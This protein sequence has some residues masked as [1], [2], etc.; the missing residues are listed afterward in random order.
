MLQSDGKQTGSG[1]GIK[2]IRAIIFDLNETLI[3]RNET[4]RLFLVNHYSRF[5]IVCKFNA[6]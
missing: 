4:M 2:M 6:K 1:H 5:P 3:D